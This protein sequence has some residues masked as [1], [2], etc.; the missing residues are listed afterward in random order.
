MKRM[1]S[2]FTK[3]INQAMIQTIQR[4]NLI[5]D[6]DKI[7]VALS[8]GPD[9]VVLLHT[10][11]NLKSRYNIKLYAAH[12]NHKIRGMEAQKDAMYAAQLC[13]SLGVTFFVKAVDVPLYASENKLTLEEAARK[14]RYDMLFEIKQKISADKIAVAHNLDDQAETILMRMLRGTGI[15]GLKGMDYIRDGCVIRPLM[16]V[17]KNDILEYCKENGLSP[18]IDKSN[19]EPDYTRNKIRLN[20]IPY[21]E[22]EF[23]PNLKETLSRMSNIIREDSD[24]LEKEAEKFFRK[25]AVFLSGNIVKIDTLDIEHLHNSMKKRLVRLCIHHCLKNLEG[26]ESIHID[27]VL[28]L[29]KSGRNETVLNLPKGLLVYKKP[30]G[31]Y[32]TL[33]QIEHTV[34]CFEYSLIPGEEVVIEEIGMKIE[35]KVM[36][37]EKCILLPTGQFTKAFDLNK[38]KGDIKIRTRAEGDKMKPMGLGGTKKLKDIFIDMKV[39]RDKRDSI[40]VVCDDEGIIWLVGYKISEDY[41]IDDSTTTVVR[42]SCKSL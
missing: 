20:L 12:L 10:L 36:A 33:S 15:K 17:Q 6:G 26:I 9:S 30:D 40:P 24:Y 11:T 21:I 13:D 29:M 4:E 2:M 7:L 38:I 28:S 3:K 31:L 1:K 5:K 14:V 34:N 27:D 23:T 41:K 37:K 35:S 19:L 8:G 18:R 42:L 39:P 25:E 16:D 32:F 22:N